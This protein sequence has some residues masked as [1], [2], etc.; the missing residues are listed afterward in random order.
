[1]FTEQ[2]K[3]DFSGS[4]FS[5]SPELLVDLLAPLGGLFLQGA[6]GAPHFDGFEGHS[7]IL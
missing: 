7:T 3:F 1:L 4:F 5:V 2:K 6:D